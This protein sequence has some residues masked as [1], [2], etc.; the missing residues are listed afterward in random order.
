MV[1]AKRSQKLW[2]KSQMALLNGTYKQMVMILATRHKG[3][4]QVG[5]LDQEIIICYRMK[6]R[7]S[8]KAQREN[9]RRIGLEFV[10]P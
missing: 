9:V 8:K 3:D 6:V 7:L 4:L 5:A 10:T 1:D 2:F